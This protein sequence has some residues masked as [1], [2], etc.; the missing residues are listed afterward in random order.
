[1]LVDPLITLF[2]AGIGYLSGSISGARLIKALFAPQQDILETRVAIPDS[3]EELRMAAV[4]ATTI[5][6][7]LGR[8]FGCLT[9]VIDMLKAAIPTLVFKAAYPDTPYFLLAAALSIVGHNWPLY[10]RFRGGR[11]LSTIYGAFIVIDPIG[12]FATAFAG[13][14]FGLF[15]MREFLVAF[16]AGLWLMVPWFWFRTHDRAHLVYG[17]AVN[18]LF[19]LAAIPD[20]VQMIQ[21]K[22][23]GVDSDLSLAMDLTPMGRSMKKI[24]TRFRLIKEKKQ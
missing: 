2:V 8:R 15:V 3:E 24:T 5:S 1:M 18:L 21:L 6:I 16:L 19:F 17:L 13:L 11:G 22:R 14:L 23:K 9:S 4:N 10:H 12:A 7:H 20:I